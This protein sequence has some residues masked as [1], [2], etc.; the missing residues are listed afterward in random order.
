MMLKDN[1]LLRKFTHLLEETGSRGGIRVDLTAEANK[2]LSKYFVHGTPLGVDMFEGVSA[3]EKPYLVKYSRR[4][5]AERMLK[6]GEI[7][8]SP[9]SAYKNGSLLFAMQDLETVRDYTIPTYS[10]LM[11]GHSGAS[12]DGETYDISNGDIHL[13]TEV[14]D[15]YLYSLCRENRSAYANRFRCGFRSYY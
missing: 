1:M 8:I 5:Y 2:A 4:E 7:R 10:N 12:V 13:S 9:A 15:Y 3:P 11:K 14:P 6:M